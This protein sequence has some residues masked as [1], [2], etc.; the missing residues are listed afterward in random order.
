MEERILGV[1]V[2]AVTFDEAVR[3]VEAMVEEGRPGLVLA[4]NPEKVLAARRD[5]ELL[6]LLEQAA[7]RIPDGI[8]IVW[9]SRRRG[10][11]V[12]NRV[13]GVDLFAALVARAAARGWPVFLLGAAPGVAE[14]VAERLVAERPGLQVAG[15]HHGYLRSD[16]E[17]AAVVR[18]VAA[19]GARLLFV[20][21]G[22]PRQER[23]LAR[24]FA[25]T[26]ATVGMGVGGTF[27]VFAGLVPRAPA[28]VRA[29]G[30]EWL[31]RALRQPSRYRRTLALARFVWAVLTEGAG[32][33]RGR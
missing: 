6:A 30:L 29:A 10:G 1:P 13:T 27:D 11:R 14:R 9:A 24:H 21:M 19:S 7:L 3:R 12:R 2:D 20:A 17:E 4:V 8:G 16:E 26:G 33:A 23:F 28:A 31:F 15:T 25:A 18:R 32:S 5:P 22:S